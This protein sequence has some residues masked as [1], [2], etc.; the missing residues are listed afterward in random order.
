MKDSGLRNIWDWVKNN[1]MDILL[2]IS[3]F[4]LILCCKSIYSDTR[5]ASVANAKCLSNGFP[6]VKTDS[7][8]FFNAKYYCHKLDNYSDVVVAVEELK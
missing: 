6:D 5:E 1:D 8:D 7:S 3:L 2:V 4:V